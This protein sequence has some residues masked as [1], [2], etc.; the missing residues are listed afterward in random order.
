MLFASE[1]EF[2]SACTELVKRI[3]AVMNEKHLTA[4]AAESLTGGLVSSEIVRVPGVSA[5]F[6]EGCVT[7]TDGAKKRRLGVSPDTLSSHTAVSRETAREMAEG[8]IETSGSDIAVS[9]TGLAGPGPDE[10]GR[11]AGLV[12]IG[13][14]SKNGS[15][16]KELRLEG[17]RIVIRRQAA[18]E[19]LK[20][21]LGLVLSA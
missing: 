9:A 6:L 14:A 5:W 7:Y 18:Y 21:M 13:G 8:M 17:S 19:A 3:S 20:L 1:A 12:F 4:S 10:Y 15:I 16:T 2:V 11:P